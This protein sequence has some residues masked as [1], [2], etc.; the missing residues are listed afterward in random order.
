MVVARRIPDPSKR[1]KRPPAKTPEARERQLIS[2]ALDLVE[3]RI[4]NGTATSQET[5]HFLK[6]ASPREQLEREKL[7][8]ENELL[9]AKQEQILEAQRSAEKYEEVIQAMRRYSGHDDEDAY[10]ED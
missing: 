9:K 7:S 8:R 3:E 10:Y 6:L 1:P 2:L 5:T 4:I